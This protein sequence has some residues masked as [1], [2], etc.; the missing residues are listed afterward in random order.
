MKIDSV[1]ETI[2]TGPDVVFTLCLNEKN[3][4]QYYYRQL[5]LSYQ[6]D[7][8]RI[9][10]FDKEFVFLDSL[11]NINGILSGTRDDTPDGNPAIVYS[12]QNYLSIATIIKDC[13]AAQQRI[14]LA[15][16]INWSVSILTT[17]ERL[18]AT[19][20][21]SGEKEIDIAIWPDTLLVDSSGNI[22]ISHFSL[23]APP[24]ISSLILK[25]N[26][27]RYFLYSA[28]EQVISGHTPDE[29]VLYFVLG[30][31]LYE[32]LTSKP[33]FTFHP[34]IDSKQV[35]RRKLRK[36]HPLLSDVD[37]RLKPLN[38][39]ISELLTPHPDT[40]LVNLAPVK[41]QLLEFRQ[42]LK[43]S[44]D[45]DNASLFHEFRESMSDTLGRVSELGGNFD[46]T[47]I[48]EFNA[49]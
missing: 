33:L 22:R 21:E 10:Q 43:I 5:P 18:L 19:T 2:Y 27:R 6:Q 11:S 24:S 3:G 8:L 1:L 46:T 17:L 7:D 42:Q 26:L 23:N 28:P 12:F 39:L 9:Q 35:V 49:S 34:K 32:L 13:L 36:L 47:N 16:A 31:L 37:P 40:R 41:E 15:L 30:M 48:N 38:F 25:H 14:P 20:G 29:R 4:T 45:L 44:D